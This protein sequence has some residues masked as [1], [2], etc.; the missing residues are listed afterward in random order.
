MDVH[1]EFTEWALAQGLNLNGIAIH[2]FPGR[3][4]GI[5]AER[6]LNVCEAE[7]FDVSDAYIALSYAFYFPAPS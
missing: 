6:E 2:R 4:V 3:G 5:I 7:Y 1:E